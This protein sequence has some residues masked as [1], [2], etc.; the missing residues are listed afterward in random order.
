MPRRYVCAFDQVTVSAAQDLFEI[1]G[2]SAKLCEIIELFIG[3]KLD[4]TTVGGDQNALTMKRYTGT[5]TTGAGGSTITPRPLD[6]GDAAATFTCKA[7]E[8]TRTVVNT[9]TVVTLP[10]M[11]FNW[12][13][14]GFL[15]LPTPRSTIFLPASSAIVVGLETPPAA[16]TGVSGYVIVE[17]IG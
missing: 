9:G 3:G 14:N 1:T 17:E 10:C 15:W 6:P 7:N 13:G 2:G 16:S 8:T 5:Y 12:V 4:I 11:N